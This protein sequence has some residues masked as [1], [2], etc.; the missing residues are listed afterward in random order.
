MQTSR[1][2]PYRFPPI[3]FFELANFYIYFCIHASR[4]QQ[5][6][7]HCKHITFSLCFSMDFFFF[8]QESQNVQIKMNSL[9]SLQVE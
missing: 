9:F 7:S 4:F 3:S 5:A 8:K 2:Y 1:E 6:L